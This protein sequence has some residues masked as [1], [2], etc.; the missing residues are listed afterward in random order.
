MR[1]FSTFGFFALHRSTWATGCTSRAGVARLCTS[2]ALPAQ[3]ATHCGAPA[4]RT[5]SRS[6]VT[7]A[8]P[9]TKAVCLCS[10]RW[11]RKLDRLAPRVLRKRFA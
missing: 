5:Q 9:E 7:R 8:R 11:R 2:T 3:P 1:V 6:G 10:M 4:Q